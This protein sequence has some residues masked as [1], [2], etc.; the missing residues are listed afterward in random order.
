[1]KE[2]MWLQNLIRELGFFIGK[3]TQI[4]CDNS[5][6]IKIVNNPIFHAQTNT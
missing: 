2:S 6:S 4:W 1:M 5:S 3:V